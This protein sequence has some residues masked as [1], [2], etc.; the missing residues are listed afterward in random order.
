MLS[1]DETTEQRADLSASL[2]QVFVELPPSGLLGVAQC[3]GGED[4]PCPVQLH[5]AFP[6]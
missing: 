3:E 1:G 4:V 6:S 5:S 2:F